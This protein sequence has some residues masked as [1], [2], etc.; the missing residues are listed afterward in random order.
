MWGWQLNLASRSRN[1]FR[2]MICQCSLEKIKYQRF[3][4]LRNC[5]DNSIVAFSYVGVKYLGLYISDIQGRPEIVKTSL[6]RCAMLVHWCLSTF[7]ATWFFAIV[8]QK[9]SFYLH[10]EWLLRT[11]RNAILDVFSLFTTK[12][13]TLD[14]FSK[15]M[16]LFKPLKNM[17]HNLNAFSAIKSMCV[18]PRLNT[19]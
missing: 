9:M 5:L 8:G 3:F 1:H 17:I 10:F 13:V 11:S 4:L 18:F 15:R 16:Q 12:C 6:Q 19:V 7:K 14:I 2:L